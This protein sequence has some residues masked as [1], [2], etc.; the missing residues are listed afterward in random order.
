MHLKF[1]HK[2]TQ[3]INHSTEKLLNNAFGF[4]GKVRFRLLAKID[5]C[6]LSI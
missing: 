1:V 3:C 6:E 4:I 5:Q 2:N